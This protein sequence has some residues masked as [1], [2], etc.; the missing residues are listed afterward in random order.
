M[1]DPRG[2]RP[3]GAPN[4]S[5]MRFRAVQLFLLFETDPG[6]TSLR[7]RSGQALGYLMSP[8]PRLVSGGPIDAALLFHHAALPS[9]RSSTTLQASTA[10]REFAVVREVVMF[11]S[12]LHTSS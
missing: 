8:L 7:L 11:A 2:R 10:V 4:K 6:L 5:R 12:T 3:L 9:R 1:V